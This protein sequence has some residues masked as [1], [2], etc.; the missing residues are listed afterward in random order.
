MQLIRLYATI[1]SIPLPHILTY[2]T[3]LS[4][5]SSGAFI[6]P[7]ICG[8]NITSTALI[9]IAIILNKTID[10]PTV[11]PPSSFFPLPICCPKSIVVPIAKLLIRLV[12]VIII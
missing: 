11:C 6:T 7:H 9:M 1:T 3:V 8:E 12:S 5:A 2:S 4:K 10:V